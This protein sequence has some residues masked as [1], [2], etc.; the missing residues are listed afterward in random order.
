MDLINWWALDI[1]WA[2]NAIEEYAGRME[3]QIVRMAQEDRERIEASPPDAE[4]CSNVW[5]QHAWLFEETLPRSLRYACI[6]LLLTTIEAT[7][8]QRCQQLEKRLPLALGDLAG[9]PPTKMLTYIRKVGGIALPEHPFQT[10]LG[11]LVNVRNCIAHAAGNVKL[12]STPSPKEVQEAV[13]QLNGF[14][15]SGDGYIE[16]NK[17]V[18]GRLIEEA[19][20]WESAILDAAGLAFRVEHSERK[21]S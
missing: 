13:R 17:D 1:H 11:H 4:E 21:K 14:R 10:T 16:I 2:F 19:L 6:V 7:L 18:C 15:V 9:R 12:M 5:S 20:L 8:L 3:E